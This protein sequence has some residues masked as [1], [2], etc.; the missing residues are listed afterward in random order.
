MPILGHIFIAYKNI[1]IGFLGGRMK[2]N[3]LRLFFALSFL[4]VFTNIQGMSSVKSPYLFRTT[5]GITPLFTS[6]TEYQKILDKKLATDINSQVKVSQHS[7]PIDNNTAVNFSWYQSGK[8]KLIVLAVGKGGLLKDK[9]PFIQEFTKDYDVII[10]DYE[11]Q[12]PAPLYKR[13]ARTKAPLNRYFEHNYR[14]IQTIVKYIRGLGKYYSIIGHGECYS[15]FMFAKAQAL[16]QGNAPLFDKLVLDSGILSGKNAVKSLFKNPA[17]CANPL[18]G[19]SSTFIKYLVGN[20]LFLA[21]VDFFSNDYSV[22]GYLSKIDI[23][24]LFIRGCND[25]MVSDDD[26]QIMWKSL[27]GPKAAFITPYH[28][29]DSFKQKNARREYLHIENLFIQNSFNDFT[30]LLSK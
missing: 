2:T 10:F 25:T 16:K 5:K 27:R 8:S 29:S 19:E 6:K 4:H 24:V 21:F 11:W 12:N 3:L 18:D 7:L 14:E 1:K 26:F 15:A 23:P 30:K 9:L 13:I 28:H 20:R 22:Q 17:L